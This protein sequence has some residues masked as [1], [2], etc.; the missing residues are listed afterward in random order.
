VI[1]PTS[2]LRPDL[3]PEVVD[4]G[5]ELVGDFLEGLVGLLSQHLE[6][7]ARDALGDGSAKARR[8]DEVEAASQYECL[9][10]DVVYR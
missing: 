4:P 2:V 5:V 1:E 9:G 6:A 7:C 3:P 8:G 10:R